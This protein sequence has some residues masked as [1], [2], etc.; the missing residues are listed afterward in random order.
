MSCPLWWRLFLPKVW[1]ADAPR[2]AAGKI[3]AG[4][5]YQSKNALALAPVVGLPGTL[6]IAGNLTLYG[7]TLNL[8]LNNVTTVGG[9]ANDL[10]SLTNGGSLTRV[11]FRVMVSFGLWTNKQTRAGWRVRRAG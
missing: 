2:R 3:P 4:M 8:D 10:I 9:G 1:L 11:W 5:E 6:T 7:G